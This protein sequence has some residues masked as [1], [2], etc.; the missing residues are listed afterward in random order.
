MYTHIHI[1][2]ITIIY[3]YIYI[4]KATSCETE[5]IREQLCDMFPA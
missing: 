2:I 1:I 4:Y 3:I 5:I